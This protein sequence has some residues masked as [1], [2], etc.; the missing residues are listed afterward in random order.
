[1]K[2]FSSLIVKER[3]LI[4]HSRSAEEPHPSKKTLLSALCA[5]IARDWP[6][7]DEQQ[8]A[9]LV[10]KRESTLSTQLAP[11][12]AV[13]HAIIPGAGESRIAVA[14]LHEGVDWESDGDGAVRLVVMLAGGEQDHLKRLSELAGLLKDDQLLAKLV[15]ADT[16]EQFIA[17]LKGH[18][19]SLPRRL[20][21]GQNDL[22]A[23]VFAEALRLKESVAAARLILHADAIGDGRYIEELIGGR[24]VL[25]VSGGGAGFDRDFIERHKPVIMP[26]RGVRRSA[27]VQFTL[28]YLLGKGLIGE[29]DLIVNVYGRPGSGFLDSIRISHLKRE[30]DLP[31]ASG[32]GSFPPDLDLAVFTRVLQL[33]TEL[34]LEGR[35]G[36]PVGTLFVV[37]DYEG[38]TP[39]TRQM[40]VNPF[41]GYQHSERNILDPGMEETIKEY[42]RI[43]GAFIIRGDGAIE[44]AGTFL[45]GQ[46][47]AAEMQS[48]LGARHAA[49]QGISAVSSCL[50]VAISESTRRVTVFQAGRRVMEL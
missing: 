11:L 1:M 33:A 22:S 39:Y 26:I 19:E 50:A 38:V 4:Y 34:A 7:T 36:K 46:P 48:G 32:S 18:E 9:A 21:Y 49:A 43:D 2:P 42:A 27:H 12:L 3:I 28:L 13:P 25:V 23:E 6:L 17:L 16:A 24:D 10:M 41:Y 5:L 14:V 40:I 30:L 47:T 31:F 45:S 8:I 37:G 20:Y 35:E 44:S 15:E 29:D